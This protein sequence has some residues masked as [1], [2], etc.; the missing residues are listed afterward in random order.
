VVPKEN[1][2]HSSA[3]ATGE[4]ALNSPPLPVA[5]SITPSPSMIARRP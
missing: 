4:S 5:A 2:T 1:S 3:A